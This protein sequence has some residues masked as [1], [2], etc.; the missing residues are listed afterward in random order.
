MTRIAHA[1]VSSGFAGVERFVTTLALAQAG[2]G[3]EVT[4]CGGPADAMSLALGSAVGYLPARWVMGVAHALRADELGGADILNVHMT[5]T[6]VAAVLAQLS[7]RGARHPGAPI[8]ATRHFALVRAD[9]S[10][11]LGPA[12]ARLVVPRIAAQ[13]AVSHTVAAAIDGSSAVV[14]PGVPG[15]DRPS[16]PG[17][18]A[19]IVLVVQRL[20]LEKHTADA[21]DIFARSG[22]ARSGWALHVVGVGAQAAAL[23]HQ[24][25]SSGAAAAIRFL[26]FRADVPEL[27]GQAGILLAPNP[28]EHLGLSV[29]EAMAAGLPVVAAGAA[30]HLE[31]VGLVPSATLYPPGDLD[32]AGAVLAELAADPA[33]RAAYAEAARAVQR[34]H[35]TLERQVEQTDAVYRRVLGRS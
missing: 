34:E 32:A 7:R 15:E 17:T 21:I 11:R 27:M 33:A 31:T 2:A 6:E 28:A 10:G 19:R 5:A 13:I 24:A 29:V 1:V 4:V 23:R 12:V 16:D 3:H 8:V 14:H 35:F 9:G 18:R 22:L 20:E 25:A 26:G 30:G